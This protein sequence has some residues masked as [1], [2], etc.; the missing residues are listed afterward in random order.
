LKARVRRRP[1]RSG[2]AGGGRAYGFGGVGMSDYQGDTPTII[3]ESSSSSDEGPI[4][5]SRRGS[6]LMWMGAL[7]GGCF[8]AAI[9]LF[10]V[11]L[12]A[13]KD[14]KELRTNLASTTTNLGKAQTDL[15]V[16]TERAK[17][18]DTDNQD[19]T[20]ENQALRVKLHLPPPPV[21]PPRHT[22]P[23]QDPE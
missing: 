12:D 18:F 5:G 7:L 20:K 17:V 11:Y 13:S 3:V 2:G 16:V 21:A 14:V 8:I 15:A 19:L 1:T 6:A 23:F 22:N 4:A 9:F 10:V